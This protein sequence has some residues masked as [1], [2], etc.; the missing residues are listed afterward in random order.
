MK[1]K[2]CGSVSWASGD[3]Q[4]RVLENLQH[5]HAGLL[6]TPLEPRDETAAERPEEH[7]F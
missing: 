5:L 3:H 7:C 4:A 1:E 2:I 6:L